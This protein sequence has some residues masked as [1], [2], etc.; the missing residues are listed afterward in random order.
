M[1]NA[2]RTVC[3][4]CGAYLYTQDDVDNHF[5]ATHTGG[6]HDETYSVGTGEYQTVGDGYE[7]KTVT[8]QVLVKEGYWSYE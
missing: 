3:N 7:E 5:S 1:K 8:K 4:N 6:Y 2:V